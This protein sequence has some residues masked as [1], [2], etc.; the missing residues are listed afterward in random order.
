[1]ASRKPVLRLV[2][3]KLMLVWVDGRLLN[4]LKSPPIH[5]WLA[6]WGKAGRKALEGAA[7]FRQPPQVAC[8]DA[9][10][11]PAEINRQCTPAQLQVKPRS[12]GKWLK[13]LYLAILTKRRNAGDK[14]R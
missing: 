9:T 1:L 14:D 10:M 6:T 11:L 5:D 12:T 3:L 2:E 13:R 7:L 4:I 8:Y